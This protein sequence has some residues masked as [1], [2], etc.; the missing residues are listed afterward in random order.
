M[1][2]AT[3]N[4]SANT[5]HPQHIT[6]SVKGLQAITVLPSLLVV[7]LHMLISFR[8]SSRVSRHRVKSSS[9][10]SVPALVKRRSGLTGLR[11]PQPWER[12]RLWSIPSFTASRQPRDDEGREKTGGQGAGDYSHD[13]HSALVVT[14]STWM[15]SPLSTTAFFCSSH[16]EISRVQD[17]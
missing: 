1:T 12:R 3:T 14:P 13:S 15:T 17:V 8:P 4:E 9:Y 7:P 6:T 16:S 5:D 11:L 10:R 2:D